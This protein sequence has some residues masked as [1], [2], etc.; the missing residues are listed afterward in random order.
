MNPAAVLLLAAL[1]VPA[2]AQEPQPVWRTPPAIEAQ[3]DTLA[4]TGYLNPEGADRAVDYIATG[5]FKVLRIDSSGGEIMSSMRIGRALHDRRMDVVVRN[6][7]LSACA[8]Y[9]FAAAA[10]KTIEPN[11]V[12][13]WH[14]DARQ[15]TTLL[16]IELLKEWEQSLGRNAVSPHDRQWMADMRERIAAQDAFYAHIGVRD[17]IARMGHE[18][19]PVVLGFWALPVKDMAAFN[20]TRVE[21]PADYGTQAFCEHVKAAQKLPSLTCLNLNDPPAQRWLHMLKTRPRVS[22]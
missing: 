20:L 9:V 22:P 18:M 1:A 4:Y 16:R 8:N 17:G 11:S 21:A 5:H 19:S 12:V 10:R 6:L 13:A 7:C 14:G 2:L 3:G 15:P